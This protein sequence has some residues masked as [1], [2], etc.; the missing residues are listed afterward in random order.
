MTF[1]RPVVSRTG[2]IASGR[3]SSPSPHVACMDACM[4]A[5][6]CTALLNA[7]R[8]RAADRCLERSSWQHSCFTRCGGPRDV[9]EEP[10][11]HCSRPPQGLVYSRELCAGEIIL[12]CAHEHVLCTRCCARSGA[13]PPTA[14]ACS[15]TTQDPSTST[16]SSHEEHLGYNG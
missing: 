8:E 3:I 1:V 15:L 12:P 2:R 9:C 13:V 16:D 10:T 4:V 11:K 14:Y 5:H 6:H 7:K